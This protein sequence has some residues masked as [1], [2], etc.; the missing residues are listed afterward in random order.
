MLGNS[1]ILGLVNHNTRP[2]QLVLY[3]SKQRKNITALSV[4]EPIIRSILTLHYICIVTDCH[5]QLHIYTREAITLI[6]DY[7][8]SSNIAGICAIGERT[9]VFPARSA[10]QLHV[11]RLGDK[12][13]D[14]RGVVS[15]K[16]IPAHSSAL[17]ALCLTRD[18][19]IVCSASANVSIVVLTL[20]PCL[21]TANRAP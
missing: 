21:L 11:V 20:H 2:R 14:K 9:C 4:Q 5:V 15:Q 18:E 13:N 10:G 19:E 16:I 7:T 12:G 17:R 6:G 3:N 1:E 8:T